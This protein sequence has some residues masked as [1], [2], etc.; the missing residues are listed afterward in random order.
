MNRVLRNM[1]IDKLFPRAWEKLVRNGYK[2]FNA[3]AVYKWSSILDAV[4][5]YHP[6]AETVLD[7]GGGYSATTFLLSRHKQITNVDINYAGNWF[8]TLEHGK[9]EGLQDYCLSNIEFKQLNFLTQHDELQDKFYDVIID[10]CSL[11]HFKPEERGP[12]K[13]IGLYDSVLTIRNKLKDSGIFVV[14]SDLNNQIY[15][16]SPEWLNPATFVSIVEN[17]GFEMLGDRDLKLYPDTFDVKGL[18]RLTIGSFVFKKI[19]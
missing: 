14:S 7:V 12:I 19:L 11:I 3:D 15:A 6:D 17:A 5:D 9:I 18:G 4:D 1:P 10:G 8:E 2:D 16:E 13:N